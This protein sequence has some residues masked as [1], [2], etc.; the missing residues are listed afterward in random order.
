MPVLGRYRLPDMEALRRVDAVA[1]Q[2][3]QG[4]LVAEVK[5]RRRRRARA[6]AA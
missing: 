2:E 4:V 6:P 1:A 3:L 5:R